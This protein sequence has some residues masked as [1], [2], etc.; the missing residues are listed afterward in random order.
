LPISDRFYDAGASGYDE[1]FG[2]ASSEFVPTL[3]KLARVEA[4]DRVLDVATGTG[5]AAEVASD[6]VGHN[7]SVLAVDI[8]AP[9]LE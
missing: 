4:E 3:L 5:V 1:I 9:M 6:L 2:F 8:S 7:G